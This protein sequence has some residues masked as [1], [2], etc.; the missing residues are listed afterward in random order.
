MWGGCRLRD[1]LAYAGLDVDGI[2]S[3][4]VESPLRW[5]SFLGYDEDETGVPYGCFP[6]RRR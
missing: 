5:V 6:S 4:N 3:G 1:V 2:A